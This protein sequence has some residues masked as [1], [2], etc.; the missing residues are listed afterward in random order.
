MRPMRVGSRPFPLVR[1]ATASALAGYWIA[2]ALEDPREYADVGLSY[3]GEA[4]RPIL[5]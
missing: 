4:L 3:S 1:A 5:I 2:N